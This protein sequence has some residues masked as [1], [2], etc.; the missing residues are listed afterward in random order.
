MANG[1]HKI[2]LTCLSKNLSKN[3]IHIYHI[4]VG[5][6]LPRLEKIMSPGY[7]MKKAT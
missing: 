4:A 2:F 3:E 5:G 6:A 7:N 1:K